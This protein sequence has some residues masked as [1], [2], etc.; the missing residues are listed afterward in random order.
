MALTMLKRC[1]IKNLFL[2][3]LVGLI[4]GCVCYDQKANAVNTA[5]N[6]AD[7][8][9]GVK[10]QTETTETSILPQVLAKV[11]S[12]VITEK[13]ITDFALLHN[14]FNNAEMKAANLPKHQKAYLL[15]ELIKTFTKFSIIKMFTNTKDDS[16]LEAFFCL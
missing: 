9:K 13:T 10:N 6:K 1:Y 16:N 5:A 2:L 12:K 15:A 4:Y 11:G 7:Q 8:S 14:I 3:S